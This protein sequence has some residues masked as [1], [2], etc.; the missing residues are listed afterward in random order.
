MGGASAPTLCAQVASIWRRASGLKPL[1]QRRRRP[2]PANATTAAPPAS[3]HGPPPSAI[4]A[5]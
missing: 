2:A 4:I 5:R 1:P 3:P